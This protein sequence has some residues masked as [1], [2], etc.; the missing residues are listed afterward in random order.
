[1]SYIHLTL[2]H[3]DLN[4]NLWR[5]LDTDIHTNFFPMQASFAKGQ[6]EAFP[7]V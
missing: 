2:Q 3:T 7:S 4:L 6:E 1:M 5:I